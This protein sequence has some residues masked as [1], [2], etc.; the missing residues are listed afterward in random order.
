MNPSHT[1]ELSPLCGYSLSA[2]G[3]PAAIAYHLVIEIDYDTPETQAIE[4][5][6]ADESRF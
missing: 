2:M 5:V 4:I 1:G 3:R 6:E